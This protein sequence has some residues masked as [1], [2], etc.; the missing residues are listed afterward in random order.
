MD[1]QNFGSEV[2]AIWLLCKK[3]VKR[4]GH[5]PIYWPRSYFFPLILETKLYFYSAPSQGQNVKL[6]RYTSLRYEK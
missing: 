2:Q 5:D 3:T 6:T 1:E 4:A